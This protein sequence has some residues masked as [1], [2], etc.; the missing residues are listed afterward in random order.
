MICPRLPFFQTGC[1]FFDFL[2]VFGI[3]A[4]T[5][6]VQYMKRTTIIIIHVFQANKG[7]QFLKI[8]HKYI[9]K[10][11]SLNHNLICKHCL[12]YSLIG[13]VRTPSWGPLQHFLIELAS[14]LK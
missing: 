8:L 1:I 2:L 10:F 14:F 9:Y 11:L 13:G 6:P 7:Q 12:L 5:V 4:L 3:P